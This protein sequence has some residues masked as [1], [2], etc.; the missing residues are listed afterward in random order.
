M[1]VSDAQACGGTLPVAR[2][3]VTRTTG[4][5]RILTDQESM[6]I[7]SQ[8]VN[9]DRLR[10]LWTTE[11][12][13]FR[14]ADAAH[15]ADCDAWFIIF[16]IQGDAVAVN[17]AVAVEAGALP[18]SVIENLQSQ[19][20][21][22]ADRDSSAEKTRRELEESARTQRE[23]EDSQPGILDDLSSSARDLVPE[24][25]SLSLLGVATVATAGA[26]IAFALGWRPLS[27]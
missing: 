12:T 11:R 10:E 8:K 7:F 26:V 21:S 5:A 19:D 1:P 23:W 9:R 3:S 25:S 17:V 20:R 14:R 2:A 6:T 18:R 15:G 24:I 27:K 4:R 22:A 16:G 13:L